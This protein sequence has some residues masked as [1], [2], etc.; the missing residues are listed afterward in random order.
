MVRTKSNLF[1]GRYSYLLLLFSL[2]ATSAAFALQDA[3]KSGRDTVVV[4]PIETVS[5]QIAKSEVR[6]VKSRAIAGSTLDAVRLARFY[7]ASGDTQSQIYWLQIAVEN[8]ASDQRLFLARA[9]KRSADS[10]S[11]KR[12]RFWYEKII[13]DGPAEEAALAKDELRA[14]E[15]YTAKQHAKR[16]FR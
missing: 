11:A 3:P 14:W 10:L 6:P 16:K 4:R 2:S 5:S 9:L 8:G 1:F 12:A 7:G 13:Q 15:T